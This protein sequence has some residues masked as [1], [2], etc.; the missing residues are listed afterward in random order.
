M[1][2]KPRIEIPANPKELLELAQSIY[3]RHLTLA[4]T[5]PLLVMNTPNWTTLGETVAPALLL[6]KQ[7]KD[8][9]KELKNVYEQRDLLL[10][11]INGAVKASRD[12]LM[13]VNSQNPAKLGEFGFI[14]TDSVAP[15]KD[16]PA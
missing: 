14:V 13:G 15:K 16:K 4:G 9:E 7:A 2:K 3:N 11:P 6:E 12:L 10:K 5:S 8:L 1:A